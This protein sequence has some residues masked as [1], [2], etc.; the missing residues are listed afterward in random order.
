MRSTVSDRL[1]DEDS[2]ACDVLIVD[3]YELSDESRFRISPHDPEPPPYIA[4]TRAYRDIAP[5]G[6][7]RR[8]PVSSQ[9]R[10]NSSIEGE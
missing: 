1:E 3:C 4:I 2:V 5:L 7:C 10:R 9:M 8:R 6:G